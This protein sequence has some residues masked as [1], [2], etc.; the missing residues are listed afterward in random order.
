MALAVTSRFLTE[1][2]PIIF[3]DLRIS[4]GY[5]HIAGGEMINR[6]G[7]RGAASKMGQFQCD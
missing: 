2:S 5:P 6:I 1:S 7:G 4:V 3:S